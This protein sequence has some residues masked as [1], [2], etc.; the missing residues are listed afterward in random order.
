MKV[1]RVAGTVVATIQAEVFDQRKLLVCDVLDAAGEPDGTSMIAVDL[2]G[3]GAG[4]TVLVLDEGNSARQVTGLDAGP[5]RTVVI[6]I[7][8]TIDDERAPYGRS[9]R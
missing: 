5:M 2:V 1:A 7:V 3:A 4:E 9:D 8:D 6:G